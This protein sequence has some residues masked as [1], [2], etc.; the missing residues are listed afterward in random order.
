MKAR[1]ILYMSTQPFFL[2]ILSLRDLNIVV[3]SVG[4]RHRAL[5]NNIMPD[6]PRKPNFFSNN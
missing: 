3:K 4:Y 2:K 5:Y 6:K 1:K